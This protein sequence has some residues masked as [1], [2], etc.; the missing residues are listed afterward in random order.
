M[1]T[2]TQNF[3]LLLAFCACVIVTTGWSKTEVNV[4]TAGTLSSLIS[5]SEKELKVTGVINGSDI[6]FIRQLINSGKVTILDWSEVS[7]VAGG[8]AYYESY[9][10]TDNTIGEKMF[11][12]CS[13]LQQITLPS[14]IWKIQGDAFKQTGLTSI[15]IPSSVREILNSAFCY[16]NSLSTVVIGENVTTIDGGLFWGSNVKEVFMKPISVPNPSKPAYLFSSSPKIYVYSEALS[17]YK[18]AGW[19]EYGTLYGTLENYY[20]RDT[21]DDNVSELCSNIFE[22]AAC[23]QLKA[24]YQSMSD[25]GLTTAFLEAGMPEYM[26]AI[27]LKIKNDTWAAYEKGPHPQLQGL[28]RCQLLE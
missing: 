5:T 13:G 24:E 22:D 16:C 8:E 4:Q 14:T 9:T 19:S 17:D 6:K 23:T 1:K 2:F 7:I 27:A 12:E 11:Q 25:E 15:D 10:T 26:V 28:Q 20:P 21:E 3:R 18:K